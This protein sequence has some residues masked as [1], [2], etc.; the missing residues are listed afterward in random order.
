MLHRIAVI[1]NERP[2]INFPCLIAKEVNTN[3]TISS[4]NEDLPPNYSLI[5]RMVLTPT[6]HV[7][8]PKEPIVQ[9]RI[10]RQYEEEYFI[11]IVFRDEDYERVSAIQPNSLDAVIEA[12]KQFMQKGFHILDRQYEFLGCSNSQLRE[13]GFWLFCPNN[14]INAQ[15]IRDDCGDISSERCV[16][17][18]VSRFGLCFSASRDT[19]DVGV[20][21]GEEVFE[22]DIERN[23]Y[24]F[25][26]GIGK[27]SPCL[28]SK[29]SHFDKKFNS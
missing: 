29:V 1:A 26:D 15:N 12:M 23:E 25:S 17:S 9:N 8:Y 21:P 22:D 5:R 10:I 14:G 6:K 11:R 7:F 2:F 20:R 24:C 13:H 16:A 19:I 4:E 28:A 27:I 18:Y 3:K